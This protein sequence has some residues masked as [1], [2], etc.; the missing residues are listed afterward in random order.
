MESLRAIG[1]EGTKAV[2]LGSKVAVLIYYWKKVR[3][4]RE[5][6]LTKATQLDSKV[7][8]LTH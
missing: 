3:Q 7:V 2:Q 5:W 4:E 8:A 1:R 6:P